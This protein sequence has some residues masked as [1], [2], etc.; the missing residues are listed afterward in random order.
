MVEV[1]TTSSSAAAIKQRRILKII[2]S[3][4]LLCLGFCSAQKRLQATVGASLLLLSAELISHL[5][6]LECWDILN[7]SF[8]MVVGLI[9]VKA[10]QFNEL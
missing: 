1:R 6:R 3:S 2:L 7:M 4:F 10:M 5:F 9:K 8:F